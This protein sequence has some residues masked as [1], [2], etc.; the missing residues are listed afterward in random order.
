[1]SDSYTCIVVQKNSIK[2]KQNKAGEIVQWLSDNNIISKTPS[3]CILNSKKLGYAVA[4]GA[5]KIATDIPFGLQTNGMEIVM[6]LQN[7]DL[8]GL[9]EDPIESDFGFI[10]WN[11]QEFTKN[12]IDDFRIKVGADLKI[13]VGLL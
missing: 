5:R 2:N 10:F 8:C 12:F 13:V 9:E 3:N 7:F 11:W 4:D 1:M 6:N